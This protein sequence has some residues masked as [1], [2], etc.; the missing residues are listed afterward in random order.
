MHTLGTVHHRHN[1]HHRIVNATGVR[2]RRTDHSNGVIFRV[3]SIYCRIGNGRLIGSFSTRILHNSGVTLVNPGKYNGAALL[4]LVLNRLRTSD[5]H[6]RINAGL[7]IT[8]FSRRHTRLSPSGAIVSGL[9]RNGRRI[10]IGNGPHRMLNCLRSFLF[11]PGQTV[12]PMHT[13][14]NNRQ[15]H[16]LLTHLF[17]GPDGLLV[18]SRPAGSLSIRALRLLRRLVSDC[19]NAMLLIDRSHRFI[20]G[21]IAR[22]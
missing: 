2:I 17:L 19:R 22:Y 21:A 8:C 5:K 20:S 18:L 11:R 15:G 6:V 10:V 7:R 4:G 13:L 9:T 3:R 1:R 14:S 12:A 16:L